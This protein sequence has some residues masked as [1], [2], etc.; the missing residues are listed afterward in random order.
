M[1]DDLGI[2]LPLMMENAGRH[3]AYLSRLRYLDGDATDRHAVVL[4]G[5]GGNGGGALVAARR[6]HGWGANVTVVTAGAT[7][8]RTVARQQLQRVDRLGIAVRDISE[9]DD[10]GATDVVLDGIIGYSLNGAPLGQAAQLIRWANLSP[11]PTIALDVPSG[12]DATT[13]YAHDPS[14]RAAITL[15]LAVPKVGL[16]LPSAAA[17]VG[18]LYVADIGI[19]PHVLAR[20]GIDGADGQFATEEL[21]RLW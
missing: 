21:V 4:A 13:G 12:V 16:R 10:I 20:A 2:D 3:L 15:T 6:L 18:E 19:P 11:A 7:R 5:P 1:T 17:A 14:I 8:F 9:L